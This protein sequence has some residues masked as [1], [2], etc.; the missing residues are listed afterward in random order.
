MESA[1]MGA[2]ME[3]LRGFD[4]HIEGPKLDLSAKNKVYPLGAFFTCGA[5][6]DESPQLKSTAFVLTHGFLKDGS[7]RNLTAGDLAEQERF[8]GAHYSFAVRNHLAQLIGPFKQIS[9]IQDLRLADVPQEF[10][11]K[12]YYSPSFNSRGVPESGMKQPDE[13]AYFAKWREQA[14]SLGWG[15]KEAKA[16]LRESARRKYWADMK[17][18][19]LTK[20][21]ETALPFL[22]G[23]R[24]LKAKV[25][26]TFK[27]K[28]KTSD[29]KK[30]NAHK[31]SH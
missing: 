26:E 5:A 13:L 7:T 2:S 29:Q 24:L 28:Q 6:Q 20:I 23:Q 16:L 14:K 9:G 22:V 21:Q 31:H 3:T 15:M 17:S 30:T 27:Q 12:F 25:Q 4:F 8:L 10:V 18:D 19:V 1:H 11:R